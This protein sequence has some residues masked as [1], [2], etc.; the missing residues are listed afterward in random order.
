MLLGEA[1]KS[2]QDWVGTKEERIE[3]S[4]FP[5]FKVHTCFYCH[6]LLRSCPGSEMVW[7]DWWDW[8]ESRDGWWTQCLNEEQISEQG[9]IN[10]ENRQQGK[11]GR[12]QR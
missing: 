2:Q 1:D 3:P 5:K 12:S 11:Y 8:K 9:L 7:W 10:L 6:L 4:H